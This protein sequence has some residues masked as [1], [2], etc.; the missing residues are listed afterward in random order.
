VRAMFSKRGSSARNSLVP[1][2]RLPTRMKLVVGTALLCCGIALA[3]LA[4]AGSGAQATPRLALRSASEFVAAT[5]VATSA[6]PS[7][8]VTTVSPRAVAGAPIPNGYRIEIPRLAIDLPMQEGDLRRDIDQQRT[9]EGYAFHLPGT[10]IPG[11]DSNTFL[12]AHARPGMFLALWNARL[13]D[14]V[15]VRV[16]DGSVLTYVVRE[17]LPRVVPTD[18]ATTRPTASE[19]LTLQTSTGPNPGDPRFVVLAFPMLSE[20]ASASLR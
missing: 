14:V 6:V 18:V 20:S 13:G 5:V 11:E 12:Y 2:R 7:S 17:I 19:Q 9:P 16:P 15:L 8:F 4:D 10:A 3:V 1:S